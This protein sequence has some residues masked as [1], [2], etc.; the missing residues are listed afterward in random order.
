[1]TNFKMKNLVYLLLGGFVDAGC[2]EE[3]RYDDTKG[4]CYRVLPDKKGNE[5]P[6]PHLLTAF[7]RIADNQD[8]HDILSQIGMVQKRLVRILDIS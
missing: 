2:S 1:M 4:A 8:M 7:A 5:L 6:S 3:E